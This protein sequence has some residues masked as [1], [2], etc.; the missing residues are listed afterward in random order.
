MI[1][2]KQLHS[3]TPNVADH[4]VAVVFEVLDFVGRYLEIH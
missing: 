1:M 4:K 3:R 2:L